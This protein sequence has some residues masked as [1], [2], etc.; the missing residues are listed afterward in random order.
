MSLAATT[1]VRD[2]KWWLSKKDDVHGTLATVFRTI[3]DENAWR[4]DADEYH[5]TLYAGSG[6]TGGIRLRSRRNLTYASTTLP[7]NVCRSS[8]D[9]L[10]AKIVSIRPLPQVVT[11]RGSWTSQRKARKTRQF[12]EGEF[13]RCKVHDHLGKMIVRDAL[14]F[15]RGIVKGWAKK[16]RAKLERAHP[17]EVFTDDWDAQHGDPRNMYHCRTMDVGVAVAELAGGSRTKKEAIETAGR[18]TELYDSAQDPDEAVTV[19]RVEV[20]EAWHLCSSHDP[21][22]D[23]HKCDGRHVIIVDGATL[24]DE[25]WEGE[26]FPFAILHYCDAVT[27][28]W[29][30]GLIEQIEGHQTQIN[31][32]NE[33]LCDQYQFSGKL[34]TVP[35]GS[36][37][38]KQHITN[39]LNILEC[40]RTEGLGV[41]DL[42]LVNEHL[43]MRPRELTEDALNEIGLSQMSVQS[44]K[45]KGITAGV[46]LQTLD[47]VETQRFLVFG[48]S[49]E[50]WCRDVAQLLLDI[51]KGIAAEYGDYAT[52]VPMK[53]GYLDLK[54][55]EIEVDGI[56][57]QLQNIASLFQS[58]TGRIDRLK[59][60]FE[61]GAI[62]RFDF[63]RYLDGPDVQQ[64]MDVVT[65]AR[66]LV[67]EILERMLDA[68]EDDG[69]AAY[70]E[71]T[72][73]LPLQWAAKRGNDRMLHAQLNGAPD[74]VLEHVRQWI[75]DCE[76]LIDQGAANDVADP[77]APPV[78]G[79]APGQVPPMPQPA[80]APPMPGVMPPVAA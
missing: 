65:S 60:L 76:W 7:N 47:D 37:I 21:D 79:A 51:I 15:G 29:G 46:A 17:W 67:D 35:D 57:L 13:Y 38:N 71:P 3:Y 64:E 55:D 49:F 31:L 34:V 39:G 14:M 70:I 68:Q 19:E 59:T 33:K 42:D 40:K 26:R 53:G 30:S 18:F 56:E 4:V 44:Q 25:V 16:K 32:S 75:D 62:D 66:L 74:H 48:R 12:L 73:Y 22:D 41:F 43:R 6:A 54:W 2:A 61:I 10:Q 23:D 5:A 78:E 45:P 28:L 72:P 50:T 11:S 20:L 52:R 63:M 1:R 9:T 80:G 27:G 58:V 24:V 77:T 36:G 69:E 8:T